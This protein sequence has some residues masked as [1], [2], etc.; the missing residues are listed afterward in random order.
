MVLP[1]TLS[2]QRM[3]SLGICVSGIMG[4][5]TWT[6]YQVLSWAALTGLPY[7]FAGIVEHEL[8][9]Q[10]KNQDPAGKEDNQKRYAVYE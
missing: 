5:G 7:L 3:I 4:V 1:A 8:D 2:G 10:E 9:L 6:S